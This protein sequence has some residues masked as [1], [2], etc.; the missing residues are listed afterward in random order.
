MQWSEV[1]SVSLTFS[2]FPRRAFNA[3]VVVGTA[4][5]LSA[6][7]GT[8]PATAPG[9]PD[10]P[11]VAT[12]DGYVSIVSSRTVNIE[13]AQFRRWLEARQLVTFMPKDK[14]LPGVKETVPMVGTWG[15][16]GAIRRVHLDDGHFAFDKITD[17]KFPEHF[18]Y[19]V[20]GF[21]N[22]AGRIAEYIRA[23]LKYSEDKAGVTT[24]TWTYSMRPK[25][26]ITKPVVSFF[27]NNRFAPFMEA[28]LDNMVVAA[29]AENKPK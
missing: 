8:P 16:N 24:L 18:Q 25:S 28:T 17:N 14:G 12:D 15:G 19:Q 2:V 20:F 6:C 4:A 9:V 10:V 23:E 7:A 21:T 1:M 3:L 11:T 5:L 29:N 13:R 26:A 27:I 22:F